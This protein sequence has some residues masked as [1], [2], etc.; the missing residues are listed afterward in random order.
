MIQITGETVGITAFGVSFISTVVYLGRK[1]GNVET[2]IE[3]LSR[4]QEKQTVE[5]AQNTKATNEIR[6]GVFGIDGT[7]GIRGELKEMKGDVKE[8][9]GD[10]AELKGEVKQIRELEHE[11]RNVLTRETLKDGK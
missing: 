1:F 6:T 9:T 2:A 4:T 11:V 7:N 10:V 8:L 5:L 3:T